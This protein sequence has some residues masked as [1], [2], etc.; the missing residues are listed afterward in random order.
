VN[1]KDID[2]LGAMLQE[3]RPHEVRGLDSETLAICAEVFTRMKEKGELASE[4]MD[5]FR[6]VVMGSSTTDDTI[7]DDQ[8][9]VINAIVEPAPT[10]RR[11]AVEHTKRKIK[12]GEN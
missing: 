9:R 8:G 1:E 2:T 11:A 5:K 7:R 6:T 4:Q 12:D 10:G 3:M